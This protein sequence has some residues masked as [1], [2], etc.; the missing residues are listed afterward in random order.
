M[1]LLGPAAHVAEFR[2]E[3]VILIARLGSDRHPR[4][5]DLADPLRAL[6]E[7]L[8]ERRDLLD[9][10]EDVP[11]VVAA[12]ASASVPIPLALATYDSL[13]PKQAPSRTAALGRAEEVRECTRALHELALLP[14]SHPLACAYSEELGQAMAGI[15]V[16][17]GGSGLTRADE[18]SAARL[19]LLRAGLV[20]FKLDIDRA[21]VVTFDAL[22][23]TLPEPAAAEAF[24]AR[25]T[26]ITP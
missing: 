21:R 11:H 4:V 26:G 5:N 19:A 25:P 17:L 1:L 13:F 8:E 23:A 6:L 9:E 12:L 15:A 20:R 10:A 2:L 24:F 22:V 14:Q 7:C 16:P 18:P 3:L